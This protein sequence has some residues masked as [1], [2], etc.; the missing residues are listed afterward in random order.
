MYALDVNGDGRNDI[1]TSMA[2]D[3]GIFWLEQGEGGKWT[4][5]MI[6]DSWSQSHA[7]TMADLNQ[8]GK[9]DFVTGKRYMAHNGHDPGEREPLGIYWYE[10][11]KADDGKSI[12]WV[13][14]VV[15]YG[16]RTGSG[17]MCAAT[18]SRPPEAISAV[19]R[20]RGFPCQLAVLVGAPGSSGLPATASWPRVTRITALL[21][22]LT[23]TWCRRCRDRSALSVRP[24]HPASRRH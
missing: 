14:H 21:S 19:R 24:R 1:V 13:K 3:Y 4:K 8:D 23:R 17:M 15:D 16:S 7:M 12:Q 5:H 9:M 11:L 22:S 10:Y 20:D 18:S 6:D 2:H